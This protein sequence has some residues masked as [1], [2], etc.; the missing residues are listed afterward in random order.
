AT[1]L[2]ACLRGLGTGSQPSFWERLPAIHCPALVV[3]GADDAKF[4]RI[5]ERMATSM[6][7]AEW[8]VVPG[9]GHQVHFE[10]PEAWRATVSPFL[11]ER[12]GQAASNP[13][14]TDR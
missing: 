7:R 3:T 6:R 2:S 13:A 9:A 1:A 11:A 5:G 8:S 14:G 12:S 10:A 4:C